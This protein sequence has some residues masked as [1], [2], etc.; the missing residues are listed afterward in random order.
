MSRVGVDKW[1]LE[2]QRYLRVFDPRGP[3][4]TIQEGLADA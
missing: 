1:S 2:R 3:V 4:L